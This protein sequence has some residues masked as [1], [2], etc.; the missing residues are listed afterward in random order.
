M[1][2]ELS[3]P[4][5]DISRWEK[6][7]KR[8]SLLNKYYPL[9]LHNCVDIQRK[10]V[11][12][13][14]ERKIFTIVKECFIKE[15]L[16]FIGGYANALY[17]RYLKNYKLQ[18]YPDF[19]VLSNDPIKTYENVKQELA[20]ENISVT[21]N[22]YP[23]IGELI[24]EHYSIQVNNE[25][26]AFIY[27]PNA[28]HS[29]NEITIGK[30]K[31]KIAT[32]DTLLSFYMAFMYADRKYYDINRLLCLSSM[33]FNVQQHNRLKQSG[34]LKRFSNKCYG[35]QMSLSDIRDEKTKKRLELKP[36][37]KEYENWF[38]NY[39]PL[40]TKRKTKSKTKAKE[41]RKTKSKAKTKKNK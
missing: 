9:K 24:N 20:K 3:R 4:K 18:Y 12:N 28:C 36:N 6:I 38:L 17:S 19:D 2:L 40:Q 37:T 23:P 7:L 33:L 14:N 21:I 29:Y 16:V 8:L 5:G 26:V 27:K 34:L 15:N 30:D 10:M 13:D 35:N 22:V 41:K 39:V 25:Y 31:V 1:Y 11:N 32:I